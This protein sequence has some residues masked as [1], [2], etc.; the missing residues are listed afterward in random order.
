MLLSETGYVDSCRQPLSSQIPNTNFLCLHKF[1][2]QS[3][4]ACPLHVRWCVF[5]FLVGLLQL[6]FPEFSVILTVLICIQGHFPPILFKMES[7][8]YKQY[9]RFGVSEKSLTSLTYLSY[10]TGVHLTKLFLLSLFI[11]YHLSLPLRFSV[12]LCPFSLT[13]SS[14]KEKKR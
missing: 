11:P 5:S 6:I 9:L 7:I 14:Q 12:A 4:V 1:I 2:S 8:F 10:S 3:F 13:I